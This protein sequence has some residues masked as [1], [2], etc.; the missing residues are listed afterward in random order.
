[1]LNSFF[2]PLLRRI[3][4]FLHAEVVL[5]EPSRGGY[6]LFQDGHRSYFKR[7]ALAVNSL[8][9]AQVVLDKGLT[10]TLLQ[11]EGFRVPEGV[12]SDTIGPLEE[13]LKA[14]T[15]PLV[16]KPN[17]SSQMNGV[18]RI[19][20]IEEL[21]EAFSFAKKYSD[22]VRLE[23]E[24]IGQHLSAGVSCGEV[25]FVYRKAPFSPGEG[26]GDCTDFVSR[27]VQ[28][29]L[30]SVAQILYIHLGS[31]DFIYTSN[32]V[33]ISDPNNCVIIEVNSAPSFKKYGEMGDIELTR[34]EALYTKVLE[35][36]Q[37][38]KL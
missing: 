16:V 19:T 27:E 26:I 2:I 34:V 11:K 18:S 3:A 31:I 37:H 22:V 38:E 28:E 7:T 29:H 12:Q 23:K 30:A 1:M 10:L 24:I 33:K 17:S 36:I 4:G 25:F 20:R 15:V 32:E 8:G 21:S 35:K 5:D 14:N 13:F 6:V 9:S